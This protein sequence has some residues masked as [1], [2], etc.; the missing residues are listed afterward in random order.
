MKRPFKIEKRRGWDWC[1]EYLNEDGPDVQVMTV[2]GAMTPE[3][4]I[5]DARSS[6]DPDGDSPDYEII[7]VRRLPLPESGQ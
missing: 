3:Q 6:L 7:A 1:I 4:A 2:F 5:D